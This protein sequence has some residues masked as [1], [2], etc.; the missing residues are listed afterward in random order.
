MSSIM[1]AIAWIGAL[2]LVAVLIRAK[3]SFIGNTLVPA[4][5]IAGILGFILMNTTGLPGSE[6][7]DYTKI[8]SVLYTFMFINLGLTLPANPKQKKKKARG[9]KEMRANMGN[10]MMS[11]VVGMGSTWAI[12]YGL[13]PLIGFLILLLFGGIWQM[14]PTYG[15]LIP[16]GFAQG[17]G[18]A[19]TYGGIIESTGWADAI[20]VAITFS[21]IGFIIAYV[22]GVP[23]AKKGIK[24]GVSC[25]KQ[26]I[27][28]ELA[29]GVHEPENQESYGKL[30]TSSGNLDVLTFHIAFIGIA[31][32]I[33]M[34]FGKLWGLIPGYFGQLFSQLLFF[35][36]M[37]AAYL[38]RFILSKLGYSKYLDRGTQVRITNTSTD[39]MVVAAFAAINLQIVG[40]WVAPILIISAAT[41]VLTWFTIKYFAQ[42][43]GGANDFERFLGEWG[44]ATGTNASGLSLVRIADPENE[45]TTAAELGP[46]NIINVPAS[47]V[48]A[49][50]ICA[51]ADGSMSIGGL[52]LALAGTAVAY[53]LFMKLIGVWGP[54]TYDINTGE[55]FVSGATQVPEDV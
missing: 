40:K 9:I 51:Y 7:A 50:A 42:R 28:R 5:V 37:L 13:Q 18:Q 36:G 3:V 29:R 14:D 52:V 41:T 2:F 47:Y 1:V 54:K 12:V 45:T 26:T 27:S 10:S 25:S 49:P 53:M 4:C 33:G 6:T 32:L 11:G 24:S 35:N 20:Q 48:I 46:A 17:P 43:Y 8:S 19:V 34:Q 22:L 16:F 21:A 15:L 44:T 31:W 55:K 38:I 30:T 39:I 23:Y